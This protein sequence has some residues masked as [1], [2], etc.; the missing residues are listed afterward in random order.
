[1]EGVELKFTPKSLVA[2]AAEALKRKTGARGLR[3]IMEELMLDVMYDIPSKDN[4]KECILSEDVVNGRKPPMLV[5]ETG[6]D[7]DGENR[8]PAKA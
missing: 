6:E 5:Y 1:M 2:I 8:S 3:S 4:I 7:W